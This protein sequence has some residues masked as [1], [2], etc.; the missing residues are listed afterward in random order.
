MAGAVASAMKDPAEASIVLFRT[1]LALRG[2]LSTGIQVCL[3][4][5]HPRHPA[6]A[7]VG[8]KVAAGAG[9]VAGAHRA[10]HTHAPRAPAEAGAV[11]LRQMT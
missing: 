9:D 5:D 4:R 10:A 2:S 7:G 11:A 6:R 8:A 1:D 3:H